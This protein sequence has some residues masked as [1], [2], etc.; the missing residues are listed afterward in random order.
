M[1]PRAVERVFAWFGLSVLAILIV[2]LLF[3]MPAS[4]WDCGKYNFRVTASGPSGK[5]ILFQ[6][7]RPEG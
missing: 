4:A 5:P 6:R 1:I 3:P 2:G 7:E